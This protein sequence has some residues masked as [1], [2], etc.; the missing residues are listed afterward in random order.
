MKHNEKC[1]SKSQGDDP[2]QY[3]QKRAR[4]VNVVVDLWCYGG[5]AV[6]AATQECVASYVFLKYDL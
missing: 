5:V 3:R 2:F 1:Q 4:L 6:T